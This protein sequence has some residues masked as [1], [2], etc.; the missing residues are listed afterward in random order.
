ME[1][2]VYFVAAFFLLALAFVIFRIVVR[3]D[4]QRKGRL[5]WLSVLFE[6]L[7]FALHANFSYIY[8]PAQWPALP[9]W[10]ENSL[11]KTIG[12]IMIVTGLVGVAIG[13]TRLGF[14][15][16]FGQEVGEIKQ[17]GLYD[18]SRNPQ[19]IAYGIVVLGWVVLWPSWYGLGWV[20]LY[21]AIAHMMVITEEEHLREVGG[22]VYERY[23]ERVPRY[24]PLFW[25]K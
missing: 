18:L 19:I 17:T 5:T 21:G 22:E 20:A 6:F 15:R 23:C 14:G 2:V 24:I 25:R 8:L 13:M 16:V 7:I 4:Y 11:L 10:P 3:R 1:N 12:L 9:G